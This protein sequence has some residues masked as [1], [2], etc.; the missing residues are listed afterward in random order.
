MFRFIQ[1]F[2]WFYI[3]Y[4]SFGYVFDVTKEGFH[5]DFVIFNLWVATAVATLFSFIN[6][7]CFFEDLNTRDSDER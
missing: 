7:Y 5:S 2:V 4:H 6:F 1:G 3:A